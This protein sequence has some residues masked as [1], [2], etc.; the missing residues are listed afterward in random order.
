MGLTGKKWRR[1]LIG[2][3]TR[4]KQRKKLEREQAANREPSVHLGFIRYEPGARG[5]AAR[6]R[7]EAEKLR[8]ERFEAE[9]LK[10]LPA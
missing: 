8:K 1:R 3:A 10:R 6:A 5:D 7:D 4:K 2:E 9:K